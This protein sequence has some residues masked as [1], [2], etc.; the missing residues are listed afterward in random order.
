MS[1]TKILPELTEISVTE[2]NTNLTLS[3]S[4]GSSSECTLTSASTRSDSP[5]ESFSIYKILVTLLV[6]CSGF[7]LSCTL[8]DYDSYIIYI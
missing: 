6:S 2:F 7:S 1:V 5:C 4:Y 8:C 3:S